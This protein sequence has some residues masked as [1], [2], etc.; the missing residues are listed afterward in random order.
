[1]SCDH[2]HLQK[3]GNGGQYEK[4]CSGH[5]WFWENK[6]SC[7]GNA[8]RLQEWS[9]PANG[10]TVARWNLV[11][12]S[13]FQK[14][15]RLGF[16]CFSHDGE[17]LDPVCRREDEL[18]KAQV[19]IFG[20]VTLAS[21]SRISVGKVPSQI[22]ASSPLS[23]LLHSVTPLLVPA[24]LC[25]TAKLLCSPSGSSHLC[26][27]VTDVMLYFSASNYELFSQITITFSCSNPSA[28]FGYIFAT[29]SLLPAQDAK[30][31]SHVNK[32]TSCPMVQRP[33]QHFSSM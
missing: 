3:C 19:F 33:L 18:R 28:F 26:S 30:L 22:P 31:G 14:C 12:S 21:F 8:G 5:G 7:P 9:R 20:I 13:H 25:L 2:K 32:F 16:V 10:S 23:L 17:C 24:L 15:K 4:D 6:G 1:M 27:L 29:D 11:Q